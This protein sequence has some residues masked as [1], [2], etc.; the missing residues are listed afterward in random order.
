MYLNRGNSTEMWCIYTMEFYSAIKNN[1][2]MKFLCKL[3]D[4]E[5]VILS[6]LTQSQKNT[7]CM[8]SLISRY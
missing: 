7:C 8:H 3:M 2:L 4:L 6:E 1:E 5:N